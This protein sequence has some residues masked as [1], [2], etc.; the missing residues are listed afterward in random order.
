MDADGGA[1][2]AYGMEFYETDISIR[3]GRVRRAVVGKCAINR[4]RAN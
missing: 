3:S 4:Y 2:E 1:S